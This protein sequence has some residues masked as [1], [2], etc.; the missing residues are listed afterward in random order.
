MTHTI[1]DLGTSWLPPR[2]GLMFMSSGK[3]WEIDVD[4]L[5]PDFGQPE[6]N[7]LD[8][9]SDEQLHLPLWVVMTKVLPPDGK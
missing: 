4:E 3:L 9:N 7:H 5:V 8:E 2:I 6:T 1:D